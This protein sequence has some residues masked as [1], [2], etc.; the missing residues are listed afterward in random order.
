M[1][2]TRRF[3]SVCVLVFAVPSGLTWAQ[4]PKPTL[5]LAS[6]TSTEQSGLFAHLLPAFTRDTGIEVRVLALGTGQALDTARRGDA[7]ALLV[8]DPVAETKFM[9]EGYGDLRLAVM[10]NDF[11]IV[12]PAADPAGIKGQAVVPAMQK[13]AQKGSGWI[14][15]GDK[16]GTHAMELRLWAA[17]QVTPTWGDYKACGCG[18]GPA[19]NMA[20][21][22]SAYVLTDRATWANF[23]NKGD[24]QVLVEGD[25]KL[26]NPYS[27]ITISAGRHPHLQHA[28]AKKWAQWLVSPAGQSQIASYQVQGQQL[29]FPDA[30]P[31]A[32][33]PALQR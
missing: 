28:N 30:L 32:K 5:V 2:M 8:H 9:D 16:S 14:S 25:A 24:L 18:M 7:D 4:A 17:G 6:T 29:F 12:G 22:V 11:V 31:A 23:K 13:I 1:S 20:A 10:H 33:A 15:R 27:V 26:N 21:G 19:L 3:L